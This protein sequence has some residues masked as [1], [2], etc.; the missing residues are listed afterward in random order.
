MHVLKK[1]RFFFSRV[2]EAL[3]WKQ[4]TFSTLFSVPWWKY[5]FQSENK[6]TNKSTLETIHASGPTQLWTIYVTLSPLKND[7]P[8]SVA[9]LKRTTEHS[10][11]LLKGT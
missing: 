2:D 10:F 5:L 7:N 8:E 4:R 9:F 3:L 1:C 6:C 11:N